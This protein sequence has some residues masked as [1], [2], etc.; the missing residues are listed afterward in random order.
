[1]DIELSSDNVRQQLHFGRVSLEISML[2]R[3]QNFRW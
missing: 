1:M 3:N 2:N